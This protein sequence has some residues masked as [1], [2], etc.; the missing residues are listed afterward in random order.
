MRWTIPYPWRASTSSTARTRNWSGLSGRRFGV[1]S[2]SILRSL[3]IRKLRIWVVRQ[4]GR[5]LLCLDDLCAYNDRQ[6]YFFIIQ[7][8]RREKLR[9]FVSIDLVI[10]YQVFEALTP[11]QREHDER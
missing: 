8:P 4:K 7:R 11:F 5:G 9:D 10:A 6:Q 2:P 1:T 3:R